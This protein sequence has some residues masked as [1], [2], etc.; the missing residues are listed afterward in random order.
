MGLG[1]LG[2]GIELV[3]FLHEC[4]AELL[5]TDLKSA[6]ELKDALVQLSDL[7]GIAYVLGEH[8]LSDF[9]CCD[10]VIKAA[11]VPLD[12][13]YIEEARRKKIP[14]NMD[15]S[16]FAELV[17]EG[18]KIIGI[19]GTKGKT[20]VTY[21]VHSIIQNSL[22]GR[23]TKVFL[24]GNVRG[25]AT[26]PLLKDVREGDVVV[27]ELD[28]WQLQGFDE[29][30][31]SPQISVFT[32][33][34]PDHQNYYKGDMD[35]YWHDKASIFRW[36]KEGDTLIISP[37]IA[38]EMEK[39]VVKSFGWTSIVSKD[40]VPS[41]WTL[42]MPGEH[43]RENASMALGVA[44]ALNIPDAISR[45]AL[46]K[47]KGVSGRLEYLRT[48]GG[49]D[50]YNDGNAT[51][52]E[53]TI[54]ALRALSDKTSH[55]KDRRIILMMG[56][57]DKGLDMGALIREIGEKCKAV[58]L[59]KESGSDRIKENLR[60][61]PEILFREEDGLENT[62]KTALSLADTEDILLFSPAFSS[63]GKWF[64]N[65]YDRNDQFVALVNGLGD[66]VKCKR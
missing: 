19:T 15:A 5:V 21:L 48:I 16:L 33:F 1:L 37:S 66:E 4:G 62:L 26:L 30:K 47:F 43:N 11:G 57:T 60:A 10:M 61:L 20:T 18:V 3:R 23:D 50:I 36:Q 39:R 52:P 6:E 53:A 27:L 63:F 17:P 29:A 13:D 12:S 35:A 7:E 42:M 40:S 64:K 56:G 65:E 14:I 25:V 54:V 41:E 34:F 2:R 38:I 59:L 31:I 28:S 55:G 24:G 44:R 22:V 9:S 32:N 58:V 51:V 49:V 8:R 46:E 45:E